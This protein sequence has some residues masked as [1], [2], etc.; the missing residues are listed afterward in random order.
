MVISKELLDELLS[1]IERPEDLLGDTG[2]MKQLKVRLME[3]VLDAE[4]TEHPLPGRRLK[5]NLPRRELSAAGL[6]TR[7]IL[8]HLEEVYGL[9]VSADLISRVTDAVQ[10]EVSGRQNRA[11]EPMYPIH[12]QAVVFL[13]TM[14]GFFSTRSGSKPVTPKAARSRTRPFTWLLASFRKVNVRFWACG[15]Q[16]TRG[17]VLAE[18][19]E[20]A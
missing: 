3:Q 12:C 17:Q 6:S 5:S 14:R 19:H 8:A 20:Q 2:L 1:G 13:Q 10:A 7:D 16:P 4:L 18:H 11:L 9:L 15:L